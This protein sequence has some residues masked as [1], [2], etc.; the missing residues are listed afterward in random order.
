MQTTAKAAADLG[1]RFLNSV[2]KFIGVKMRHIFLTENDQ[3]IDLVH[4]VAI[5]VI[6][7]DFEKGNYVD[8]MFSMGK[9]IRSSHATKESAVNEKWKAFEMMK[10][11][12]TL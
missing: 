11:T 12:P 8:Y 10:A 2:T 6:S 5:E 9:V 4:V 1:V 7:I 3:I